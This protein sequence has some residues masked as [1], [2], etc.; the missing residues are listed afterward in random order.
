LFLLQRGTFSSAH[1]KDNTNGSSL[2]I[3]CEEFRYLS[4][5]E[6]TM[7]IALIVFSLACL[8]LQAACSRRSE[9]HDSL[10]AN[11]PF[12]HE[13]AALAK[14]LESGLNRIARHAGIDRRIAINK[15]YDDEAINIYLLDVDGVDQEEL[16]TQS[17]QI[18]RLLGSLRDNA[19]AIPEDIIVMDAALVGKLFENAFADMMMLLQKDGLNSDGENLIDILSDHHRI[20]TMRLYKG[21][22]DARDDVWINEGYGGIRVFWPQVMA[23]ITH[24]ELGELFSA[25]LA[26][27]LFH[28]IGHLE[29][30]TTGHLFPDLDELKKSAK[31]ATQAYTSHLWGN[32]VKEIEDAAD[33]FSIAKINAY[34]ANI[35]T[36]APAK[37]ISVKQWVQRNPTSDE[38]EFY[39]RLLDMSTVFLLD[40]AQQTDIEHFERLLVGS[41]GKYFRDEVL[42][43]AFHQ[44][45][46]LTAEDNLVRFYHRDCNVDGGEDSLAYNRFDDLVRGERGFYPILTASD[47]EALRSRFFSHVSAGTHSHNFYRAAAILGAAGGMAPVSQVDALRL[48]RGAQLFGALMANEPETLEPDFGAATRLLES[49]L[50]SLLGEQMEFE[51]AVSCRKLKCRIGRFKRVN[52]IPIASKAFVEVASNMQGRVVFARLVFPL[53]VVP[54]EQWNNPDHD[55]GL[56]R[57]ALEF[58]VSVRFIQNAFGIELK[59]PEETAESPDIWSDRMVRHPTNPVEKF[60]RFRM[61]VL[62]CK[63]ASQRIEV[64]DNFVIEYRTLSDDRWI[65]IEITPPVVAR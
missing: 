7:R 18:R 8:C 52:D 39:R 46:G 58:L 61:V 51:D 13:D 56:L 32:R 36:R 15:P 43:V 47:W 38:T 28:E 49:Q 37:G 44:F 20:R 22:L 35:G 60:L 64:P 25:S 23:R 12:R 59:S 9:L 34:L 30:G 29:D 4:P 41:S 21:L 26:P 6:P 54:R 65:S 40:R 31:D 55:K 10:S 5:G 48:D 62:K 19:I 24:A 14:Q 57:Q 42:T 53:F 50:L 33:E 1:A 45:R 63:A 3:T 16:A 11:Q 17:P 2:A 27:L